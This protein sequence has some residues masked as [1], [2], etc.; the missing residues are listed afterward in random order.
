MTLCSFSFESCDVII[1]ESFGRLKRE[2]RMRMVNG[3]TMQRTKVSCG[4]V[5][6]RIVFLKT[7]KV[8]SWK[9]EGTTYKITTGCERQPNS[10]CWAG[11]GCGIICNGLAKKRNLVVE[12]NLD[13]FSYGSFKSFYGDRIGLP[14]K[15]PKCKQLEVS[16]PLNQ[17]LLVSLF[18]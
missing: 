16:R 5:F 17:Q 3:V 4:V 18:S 15:Y 8:W 11:F 6:N 10:L 2:T 1:A 14:T 13:A 9:M 12:N 7:A